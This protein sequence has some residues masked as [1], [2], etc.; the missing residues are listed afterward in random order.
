MRSK[1]D[2][3]IVNTFSVWLSELSKLIDG[4]ED[5]DQYLFMNSQSDEIRCQVSLTR[6]SLKGQAILKLELPAITR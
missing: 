1:S 6:F 5:D 3:V 2:D 4:C